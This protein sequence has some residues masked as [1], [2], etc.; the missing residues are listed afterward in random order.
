[1]D[2][3]ADHGRLTR[4]AVLGGLGAATGMAISGFGPA[5]AQAGR[6]AVSGGAAPSS[7]GQ[8]LVEVASP[9][10][11]AL[12]YL[13]ACG[14]D[15]APLDSNSP[16]TTVDGQFR[17]T[18]ANS[19][20]AS[21]LANLPVGA[22]IKELEMYGTRTAAGVVRLELWKSTVATGAVA[23]TASAV[24]PVVAGAF[25]VTVAANDEQNTAFKSTP[26]V[27]IDAA[28]YPTTSIYGIRIGYVSPT[29]FIPL[30]TTTN[31]RIYDTRL[32]GFTKLAP[33]EE[34]TITLP[35]P[36]AVG[37]A[38]LTLTLT[39][40]EGTGGYVSVF[41]AGIA[42]PGNSSAN[43]FGANQDLANTVVTA[44]SADSKIVLR[45]GANKTDVIVD[46]AG[47]IA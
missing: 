6:A 19:S 12:R 21:V 39:N 32:P 33:N 28:A 30:P 38:V 44:V 10:Q 25:T 29:G 1:M 42:W 13:L 16:Y 5:T 18:G 35:V 15:L 7:L 36:S 41:R 43:W 14:H 4:R 31:P 46:V 24:V 27:F 47:W 9:L 45:G 17:F 37:A 20:Y 26:F 8:H 2:V 11:P 34:R 23:L 40:T 22:V 3:P